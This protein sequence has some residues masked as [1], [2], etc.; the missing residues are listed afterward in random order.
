M[1]IFGDDFDR[2]SLQL[3]VVTAKGHRDITSS[4]TVQSPHH[5]VAHLPEGAL[6]SNAQSIGVVRAT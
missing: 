1:D 6:P 4:L 5:L 2:A 3:I